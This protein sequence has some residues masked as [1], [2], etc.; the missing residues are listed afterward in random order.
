[1]AHETKTTHSFGDKPW[2]GFE[3]VTMVPMCRKLIDVASL[4]ADEK[5][6]LDEYHAEVWEKTSGL[7]EGDERTTSWLKRETV[8][9]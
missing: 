5:L 4:T 7:F 6:W 8:K 1:M 9:M 3:H 2:L